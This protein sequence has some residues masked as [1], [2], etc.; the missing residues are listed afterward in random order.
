MAVSTLVISLVAIAI[1]L[2][3]LWKSH[4]APFSEL[5][6]AGRLRLRIYPIRSDAERWFIT[7]LDVP[8]SV[9][10]EGARSGVVVGLRLRLHFPGI[11]I[12]GNC[13]F[14]GPT[15]EIAAANAEKITKNRFEWI[16]QIV[17]GDWMPFTVLPKTTVTKHFVFESRWEEPVIQEV[18]DCTLE[19]LSDVRTWQAVTT[20]HLSLDGATWSELADVGTCITY[21]SEAHGVE[22]G[23]YPPD[24]HKYT[25]TKAQIPKGGFLA[26]NSHLDYPKSDLGA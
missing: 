4:L 2:L 5:T 11:P 15:F 16:D 6:V 10:N 26:G 25:G 24:L 3:V 9:T 21:L 7:S 13:E 20:W 17:M 18:V 12:S 23:V 22:K 19:I 8:I 14:I 1:S